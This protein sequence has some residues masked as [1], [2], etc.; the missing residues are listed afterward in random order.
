MGVTLH[1]VRDHCL[2]PERLHGE[3]G[4]GG[5]YGRMFDLP[6]LEAD[7]TLLHRLGAAGGLCDG[8]DR[9]G[10][11]Q[12]EAGWPFFGQYVAH[13]L[14]ADRSPLRAHADL[15]ALR[16]MR[17]PRANLESLYGGGPG[18]SPYLYQRSDPPK[19]LEANGDLPRNQEGIALIGDPR[20]DVHVFMRQMQVAFIHALN[21]L[22]DRYAKTA[23]RRSSSSTRPGA[24]SAGTTNG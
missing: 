13:D 4:E 23:S 14:T 3:V 6:A 10:D 17:V 5:R 1:V 24:H 11:S 20:N 8:G 22:V 7:E 19:L 18:G 9:E 2:A 16:N 12:V 21:L 15:D